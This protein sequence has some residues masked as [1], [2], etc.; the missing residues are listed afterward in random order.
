LHVTLD[1]PPYIKC[2]P[3][4]GRTWSRPHVRLQTT[5]G[6]SSR[7]QTWRCVCWLRLSTLPVTEAPWVL[8]CLQTPPHI[9]AHVRAIT[10][11]VVF[12]I[13]TNNGV[14]V[15]V[16]AAGL[17]IPLA[18]TLREL[19]HVRCWAT[20][21]HD[22]ECGLTL[23][24]MSNAA[25]LARCGAAAD[26]QRTF[27]AAPDHSRVVAGEV[28][29]GAGGGG[30]WGAPCCAEM[31]DVAVWWKRTHGAGRHVNAAD[32]VYDV[33]TATLYSPWWS[34]LRSHHDRHL[35]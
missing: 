31:L 23:C 18:L 32:N 1:V 14:I 22:R 17:L 35:V 16:C 19:C 20:V 13:T 25:L 6:A 33:D 5:A 24:A 15:H 27:S 4:C 12:H 30:C 26:G 21:C 34:S 11:H 9:D 2:L 8:S 29:A 7:G 28:Q 3:A 10:A